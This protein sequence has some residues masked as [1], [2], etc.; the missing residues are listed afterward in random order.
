MFLHNV[1][2]LTILS[3]MW[4]KLLIYSYDRFRLDDKSHGR[5]SMSSD[6]KAAPESDTD[7]MAEYGD[8][9]TGW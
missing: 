1:I 5:G 2:T 8:G 6:P 3:E 4:M 9:D 7:S